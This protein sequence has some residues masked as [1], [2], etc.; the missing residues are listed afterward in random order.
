M[1]M[2]FQILLFTVGKLKKSTTRIHVLR[3]P[4]ASRTHNLSKIPPGSPDVLSV[5][6]N[7]GLHSPW[8]G[9][10]ILRLMFYH[11]IALYP[12]NQSCILPLPCLSL[13]E[14]LRSPGF[15]T[16]YV[17]R[18]PWPSGNACKTENITRSRS[19][20]DIYKSATWALPHRYLLLHLPK[21]TSEFMMSVFSRNPIENDECL[22]F[23]ETSKQSKCRFLFQKRDSGNTWVARNITRHTS[24]LCVRKHCFLSTY[25]SHFTKS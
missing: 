24:I 25:T 18:Y 13:A 21:Q 15:K 7:R 5:S 1:P 22:C 8:A 16:R 6:K 4:R 3:R 10:S 9:S 14:Y 20:C 19:V 11:R 2:I 23:Q 12:P 17:S